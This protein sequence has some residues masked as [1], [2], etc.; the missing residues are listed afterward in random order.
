MPP[1]KFL[2][3]GEMRRSQVGTTFG[4]GAI[5]DFRAGGK[6]GAPVSVVA[7]GLEAWDES[8]GQDGQHG[9][10]HPQVIK[11]PRLQDIL[12][13]DGFRLPP[14]VPTGEDGRY[15]LAQRLVGVRFPQWL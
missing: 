9:L 13:V 7:A 10:N 4:P 14:A 15:L 12:K 5:G 8:A 1:V 2:E 11:E 6:G 3:L